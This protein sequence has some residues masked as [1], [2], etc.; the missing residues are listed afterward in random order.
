MI[1]K[2]F[3]TFETHIIH[4]IHDFNEEW[5]N[6]LS[7]QLM[8]KFES[9]K[10]EFGIDYIDAGDEEANIFEEKTPEQLDLKEVFQDAF[11][12]LSDA[13]GQSL[14]FSVDSLSRITPM[15]KY[16]Y[17][18]AHSHSDIDA[19][20]IFYIDVGEKDT[21]GDL[22]LHDPRFHNQISFTG[23]KI[24]VI[25]PT[26]GTLIAAPTYV[27]HEVSRYLGDSTRLAVVCNCVVDFESKMRL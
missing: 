8:A 18:P 5:Y 15:K 23:S 10:A 24:Q 12:E 19:F 4:Q 26:R 17:K 11:R 27:W 22:V 1:N 3:Y 2:S 20:G 9:I 16:D 14:N 21:G 25:T 7:S 6:N 13:Y